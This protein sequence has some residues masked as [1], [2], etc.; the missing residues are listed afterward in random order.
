M[1]MPFLLKTQ[2]QNIASKSAKTYTSK[3]NITTKL[4][5]KNKLACIPTNA[6]KSTSR[7]KYL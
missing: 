6:F 5:H 2:K 1:R 3:L 4:K 7:K